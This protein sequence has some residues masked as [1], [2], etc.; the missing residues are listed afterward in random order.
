MTQ[1]DL[2]GVRV[3]TDGTRTEISIPASTL[4]ERLREEVGGHIEFA[5]CGTSASAVTAV[6]HET[7]MLDGLPANGDAETF[8]CHIRRGQ[9]GYRLY[10][11][12][13]F[14]GFDQADRNIVDLTADQR[15]ILNRLPVYGK[16]GAR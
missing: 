5:H 8:V 15:G 10:G 2:H 3:D 4:H 12:I 13:C 11:P 9:L 1:R 16:G 14:F 6:V 7:G